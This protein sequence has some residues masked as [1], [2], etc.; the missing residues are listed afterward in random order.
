VSW[1]YINGVHEVRRNDAFEWWQLPPGERSFTATAY[2]GAAA[3]G[4]A[5]TLPH[6]KLDH[7]LRL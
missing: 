1:E 3:A 6:R 2:Q 5:L 4:N 7:C